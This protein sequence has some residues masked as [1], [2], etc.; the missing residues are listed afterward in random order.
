VRRTAPLTLLVAVVLLAPAAAQARLEVRVFAHVPAPGYPA[1]AVV[2]PDGTVY[3]GTFKALGASSDNGPSKVF[4]FSGDGRLQRTFTITGQTPGTAHGVQVAAIDRDGILYLLDQEPA[5]VLK[6]DPRTGTQT[7]WATFK[8]VPNCPATT[9]AVDCSA[10]AGGNAP[11]PDFA[12]WGHDGSLYVTD[13]NQALIWRVPPAGGAASVWLTDARFNG[14][15]VGPAGIQLLPDGHTLMLSTGG[16]GAN[17]LTGKLYSLP[18]TADGR[19]GTLRQLWESGAAEAPDGFAVARSGNVYLALVGPLANAVVEISPRGREIA[20]VPANP[21]ANAALPVPFDAPGSVTF[22]GTEVIVGNQSSILGNTSNMALLAIAVGEPGLPLSLPPA[23]ASSPGAYRLSVRP[24]SATAGRRTR[25]GLTAT[26]GGA[27]VLG[28][29][30]RFA[31]RSMRTDRKGHASIVATL[32]GRGRRFS[33][34]LE[35][36]GR[37]LAR[38]V[39][40]TT[41]R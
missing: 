14:T 24:S 26:V 39:V 28:A 18:I 17:V 6:L 10:G 34:T 20:R 13:Y 8:R 41:R 5:R 7:T 12:A 30:A 29:T 37:V 3:A 33:A 16:G 21:I 11:E 32:H 19:P 23:R 38:T 27:P 35:L 22:D 40:T 4:A 25:F 15:I 1:N 2:A 9:P 31:G 36:R